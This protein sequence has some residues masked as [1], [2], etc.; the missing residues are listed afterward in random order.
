VTTISPASVPDKAVLPRVER[1]VIAGLAFG[2]LVGVAAA[3]LL[4]QR[5]LA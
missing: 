4:F 2:L 3:W 5:R 1:A